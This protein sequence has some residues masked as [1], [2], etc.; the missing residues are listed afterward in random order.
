[1]RKI[2]IKNRNDLAVALN[3]FAVALMLV[4]NAITR[5]LVS[6]SFLSN[7]PNNIF[8][9]LAVFLCALASVILRRKI[10]VAVSSIFILAIISMNYIVT[11][12]FH[13]SETTVNIVQFM[14]FAVIPIYLICQCIDP[15]RML[16]YSLY[17]SLISIP[18]I[19]DIFAI[20][21]NKYA[22]AYMGNIFSILSTVI[23]AMIHFKLYRK[24]ANAV[25]KI[26]YIY[27]LYI[28]V[29]IFF[30]ANRGAVVCVL[31]C[32]IILLMNEY[33]GEKRV[34]PTPLKIA[35]LAILF[36]VGAIALINMK[37][38]LEAMQTFFDNTF[39]FVPS[40]VAKM[41]KYIN[42]GDVTDGR[43]IINEFVLQGIREKPI[44]GHG[45]ET[46]ENY[47]RVRLSKYWPY[48]HQYIY[49]YLFE[50]GIVF[51]LIPIYLSLSLTFKVVAMRIT[52]KKEFAV[53]CSLV[54]LCIPKLLLS[55]DVWDS[56]DIWM[57]ITYSL[58]YTLRTREIRILSEHKA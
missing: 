9:L 5:T 22:Q 40:F 32:L 55:T 52:D 29:K 48:P 13:A 50:G 19:G 1:M 20:Q 21:Y 25:I 31:F 3:S 2:Q 58:I 39:D 56:T 17:L 57:L 18:V 43:A 36:M 6:I 28:A 15:E 38:I 14:F 33:D 30:H 7:V 34:P 37:P 10:T 27:N 8:I 53:C 24:N 23:L 45:I 42:E 47:I 12:V 11:M 46:F 44:F 41:L 49:Q 51:S 54:C 26:A 16:R 4:S 35:V